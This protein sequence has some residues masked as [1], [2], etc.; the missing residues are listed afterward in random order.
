M[1]SFC[2]QCGGAVDAA[3]RFCGECGGAI[4][5][6]SKAGA[7]EPAKEPVDSPPSPAASEAEPAPLAEARSAPIETPSL[8]APEQPS[9]TSGFRDL[10]GGPATAA[11]SPA[12]DYRAAASSAG[13]AVSAALQHPATFFVAYVV[14]AIPTYLL[15][16]YGSNSAVLNGTGVALGVG[17]LPQYWLHL[18]FLYVLTALA[19]V[20]GGLIGRSWL[21]VFPALAGIFDLTPGLNW[22]PLIPSAFH[23]T[24]LIIGVTKEP[25]PGVDPERQ[26]PR[27]LLALIGLVLVVLLTAYKWTAYNSAVRRSIQDNL[28]AFAAPAAA[29]ATT[30]TATTNMAVETPASPPAIAVAPAPVPAPAPDIA[31]VAGTWRF[32]T[33]AQYRN[34]PPNSGTMTVTKDFAEI[35]VQSGVSRVK[36]F[37]GV[38]PDGAL[39]SVS[40]GTWDRLAG[41]GSY[42]VDSFKLDIK[43][44]DLLE[45]DMADGNGAVG[46]VTFQRQ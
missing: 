43:S 15:P 40:C 19:W 14:L 30:D 41:T 10:I 31:A 6:A 7:P 8:E 35:I 37:C 9:A 22:F 4:A 3:D 44:H 1:A 2:R 16:Y 23:V 39:I 25:L 45:G 18:T 20:R 42:N 12:A 24:T 38:K 26:R 21:P 13:D 29:A 17:A 33:T 28:G 11:E 5:K 36:E 46:K 27:P 34:S 32:S